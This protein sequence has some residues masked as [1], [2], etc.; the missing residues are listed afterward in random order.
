MVADVAEVGGSVGDG[1]DDVSKSASQKINGDPVLV[2]CLWTE[3]CMVC[4]GNTGEAWPPPTSPSRI[5]LAISDIASGTACSVAVMLIWAGND[6][7]SGS[8]LGDDVPD[9]EVR[10][11]KKGVSMRKV[12][13]ATSGVPS[14]PLTEVLRKR[15]SSASRSFFRASWATEEP[16]THT[17]DAR[18]FSCELGLT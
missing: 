8:R 1:V 5:E 16:P 11:L 14:W 2:T 10:A 3:G 17:D 18:L 9:D 15:A 13:L 6:G 4:V 12:G 7:S